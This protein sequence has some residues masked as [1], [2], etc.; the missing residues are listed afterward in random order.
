MSKN[1]KNIISNNKNKLN[2]SQPLETIKSKYVL[3]NTIKANK[4]SSKLSKSVNNVTSDK[5]F[6]G[7]NEDDYQQ[8]EKMCELTNV[9]LF[10]KNKSQFFDNISCEKN[11]HIKGQQIIGYTDTEHNNLNNDTNLHIKGDT[12]IN[13]NLFVYQNVNCDKQI[14]VE[15]SVN[16]GFENELP[17]NTSKLNVNG[18]SEFVGDN[19]VYGSEYIKNNLI[20]NDK[21]NFYND[22]FMSNS[23]CL[24]KE[25]INNISILDNV[26]SVDNYKILL[27]N[28]LLSIKHHNQSESSVLKFYSKKNNNIYSGLI[29]ASKKFIISNNKELSTYTDTPDKSDKKILAFILVHGI[30]SNSKIISVKPVLDTFVLIDS[31][32]NIIKI[33]NMT[34]LPDINHDNELTQSPKTITVPEHNNFKTHHYDLENITTYNNLNVNNSPANNLSTDKLSTDELP[35]STTIFSSSVDLL[36]NNK[37]YNFIKVSGTH[38]NLDNSDI[39]D[40]S[41]NT[42]ISSFISNKS[43]I[44]NF[45]D[46]TTIPKTNKNYF[47]KLD[48][49][50]ENSENSVNSVNSEKSENSENSEKSEKNEK[51]A[52]NISNNTESIDVFEINTMK[53]QK[54]ILNNSKQSKYIEE[55]KDLSQN[56]KLE[57]TTKYEKK[58]KVHFNFDSDLDLEAFEIIK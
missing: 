22:I 42:N 35:T 44:Y 31:N 15:Q 48:S 5:N 58:K 28:I 18:N 55:K 10:V 33:E 2:D 43:E 16:I 41:D 51:I 8:V 46:F 7:F 37:N 57:Q 6:V 11:L 54:S 40:K 38:N 21:A 24:K 26:M 23:I 19:I 32:E 4:M 1:N 14:N 52:Q 49:T 12:E 25:I 53:K 45:N 20:V 30:Y 3:A 27:N 17:D 47:S 9:N 39:L 13:G 36:K 34:Q 56:N 29:S 50:H